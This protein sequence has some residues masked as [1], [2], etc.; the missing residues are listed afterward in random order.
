MTQSRLWQP[1]D[2]AP[3]ASDSEIDPPKKRGRIP[4]SAW[5][6]ILERYR[7][8]VTLSAIAREFDC[9]PG[10]ISYIIRKAETAEAASQSGKGSADAEED[11]SLNAPG[12][13]PN[14]ATVERAEAPGEDKP[15]LAVAPAP[16]PATPAPAAPLA[17]VAAAPA[18]VQ[19]APIRHHAHGLH[20]S[21]RPSHSPR[22]EGRNGDERLKLRAPGSASAHSRPT[23]HSAADNAAARND[24]G[25]VSAPVRQESASQPAAASSASI[26][27]TGEGV[28]SRLREAAATCLTAYRDWR[29]T[30]A[31]QSTQTLSEAVHELRKTLA[32][33]EIDLSASRRDEKT[34]RPM[35]IPVHRASRPGR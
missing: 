25:S 28:E 6:R 18:A 7:A 19:P 8:G 16:P 22:P 23:D 5:P 13:T 21:V 14:T 9:T 35:P 27:V 26:Q 15:A 33:I 29:Q 31:E 12:A 3:L 17:P 1:S 32:R 2:I 11:K 10:A 34:L 24:G 4:Q 30:P 20:G